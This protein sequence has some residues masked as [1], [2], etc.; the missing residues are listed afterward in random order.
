MND[1]DDQP[2][3]PDF[4]VR[5]GIWNAVT[6]IGTVKRR[7]HSVIFPNSGGKETALS[8]CNNCGGTFATGE[9]AVCCECGLA[10][11]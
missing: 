1:M 6:K 7:R 8:Y 5:D 10:A 11:C 9:P 4:K 2:K 3:W